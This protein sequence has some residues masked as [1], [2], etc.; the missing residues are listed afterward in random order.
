MKTIGI[1]ARFYG[2]EARGLGKY[3]AMLLKYLEKIDHKNRYFVFLRKNNFGEFKPN[4]SNFIKK[5]ADVP[6][7][8]LKEQVLLP[9]I[10]RKE[11]IELMHFPHFNVPLAY[12]GDFLVTIH[13]LI[14]LEHPTKR[15]TKLGPIRYFVKEKAYRMVLKRAICRSQKII[16]VSHFTKKDIIKHFPGSKGK[17]KVIYEACEKGQDG[18]KLREETGFKK[19]KITGPYL[20]YVGAA[21]PHK[22]LER[23]ILAFKKVKK[24]ALFK[25]Y[26]LVLVGG[27]NYFYKR[28]EV[29]A[30]RKKVKDVKF[31]GLVKD[32]SIFNTIF[33]KAE[34]FVFPSLYEGFGIPP[35][36]AMAR[37][38]AVT[39][40][41]TGSIPEISGNAAL[42]FDPYN[43]GDMA[44]KIK[45]I[46]KDKNL[47]KK[48]VQKGKKRIEKFNWQITAKKTLEIYNTK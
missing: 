9:Q 7:Y 6:W 34:V 23:L 37:G 20:L 35:L 22:N 32:S 41:Y 30:R 40:S 19:Y 45:K 26:Q 14:L 8:S 43:I 29:F 28:L 44:D 11:K 10:L 48:L 15:A 1:D 36:E 27:S 2:A 33:K 25:K 5:I 46:L 47:Q 24:K 39:A 3:T 31:L 17:I 18:L 38:I 42:Y 13:D 16:T 4:N 21:Y 12:K